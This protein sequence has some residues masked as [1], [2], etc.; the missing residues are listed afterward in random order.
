MPMKVSLEWEHRR[1]FY[2]RHRGWQA[3]AIALVPLGAL[4][5]VLF[6]GWIGVLIGLVFGAVGY[7]TGPFGVMKVRQITRGRA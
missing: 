2:E 5:G 6:G 3:F 1:E 7:L 4:V